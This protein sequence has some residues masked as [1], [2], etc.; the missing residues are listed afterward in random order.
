M[1]ISK[2]GVL[3][4]LAVVSQPVFT[5][6]Q[7]GSGVTYQGRIIKP[8]GDA[9]EGANVQFRMQIRTPGNESCLMYEE[10]QALDMRDSKGVFGLTINDASGT[11]TDATGL[12]LD[13]V[14]ANRGSHT[15]D[16]TTCQTGS[17]YTPNPDDGRKL[18]VYFKDETMSTW[19]P[20]PS[21]R[22]NYVPFAFEAKTIAGFNGN[23]L[24]RVADGTT[25][26]NVSPLST[27]NYNA[28][29]GLVAGT[30]SMYQQYGK[31]QGVAMPTMTGGHVLGWNAGAW[32]S[33]DPIAGVSAFAKAALPV[34]AAGDFLKDNGSGALVCATPANSGGTVTSVIAGAGL[35]GGTITT[36]GTISLPVLGAGGTAV[37]VTYDVY[38]RI[39][40]AGSLAEADIPTLVTAGKVSGGAIDSGTIG[41]S[42]AINTTGNLVTS[43]LVSAGSISSGN[44]S[45]SGSVVAQAMSASTI[46]TNAIRVFESTNNYKITI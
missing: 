10:V 28:L 35:S 38:G 5:Y 36:A 16:P 12:G 40:A 44:I 6:A 7:T 39:T 45:S 34:C 31:L 27:A 9:L 22:I 3:V 24:V 43:G 25:L 37:K 19:E 46:S 41:G 17:A 30:S 8:N 11:R 26:G 2:I 29:L 42:A 21:T 1:K 33:V 32:V 15:F 18:V 23:S 13:A 20:M 4:A 14:F